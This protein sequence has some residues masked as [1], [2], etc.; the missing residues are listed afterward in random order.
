MTRSSS[1][2]RA[3]SGDRRSWPLCA[4]ATAPTTTSPTTI[5]LQPQPNTSPATSSQRRSSVS[6]TSSA[7]PAASRTMRGREGSRWRPPGSAHQRPEH[8]GLVRLDRR[9][10]GGHKDSLDAPVRK[11]DAEHDRFVTGIALALESEGVVD[12]GLG[13]VV[14][15]V[16]ALALEAAG[17]EPDLVAV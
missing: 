9:P 16:H 11:V 4:C 3:K 2:G 7:A 5:S 13:R 15:P 14:H 6:G 8:L 1:A 12:F 10:V 17:D